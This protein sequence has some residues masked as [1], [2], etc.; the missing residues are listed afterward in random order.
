M[1]YSCIIPVYNEAPRVGGVLNSVTEV[2]A[3]TEVICVDGGSTDGSAELIGKD[4]PQ[5]ILIKNKIREGKTKAILQGLQKAKHEN[6]IMLD[7]DMIGLSP[8]ELS[9]A[10][11]LF[12][13]RKLDCL[14]MSK[15]P[16][17]KYDNFQRKIFGGLLLSMAG[18]RI[19]KKE[20]LEDALR[21]SPNSG[22]QLEIAQ[23]KYLI[24][25]HLKVEFMDISAKNTGK[26]DKFGLWQG[27]AKEIGMWKQVTNFAGI[28][29]LVKQSFFFNKER[30]A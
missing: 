24:D 17:G 29:F 30:I 22:Y 1:T 2:K 10:I 27:L 25:H 11:T 20:I 6:I 3:I 23:N 18:E 12:E 16:A 19:L 9:H 28:P 26:L 14:I 4:F 13:E 7:S 5:V 15:A 21:R 8:D